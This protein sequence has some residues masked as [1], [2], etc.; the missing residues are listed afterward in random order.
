MQINANGTM[1]AVEEYGPK[2]GL[3]LIL[4]RGLGS[5]LIHWPKNFVQ[6]FADLGYRT[7][8][9]DNRDAGL[10]Q[11][12]PMQDHPSDSASLKQIIADG[13]A[14]PV[15]Y[16]L[17]D[18]VQDCVGLMDEL[19]IN[20]AHLF[21]ISMGGGIAQSF[22]TSFA[23]RLLS[24]TLVMTSARLRS[25]ALLG[26]MLA[27]RRSRSD[28][29]DAMVAEDQVWGSPGYPMTEAEIREQ[30]AQAYDRGYDP[31]AYNRQILGL[32]AAEERVERLQK[33][34]LP[35]FVIHGAEDTLVPPEA[36]RELASLIPGAKLEII[37][38]M[39]HTITPLLAPKLV[40]MVDGFIRGQ[41]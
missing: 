27:K 32:A 5:S 10:S 15:P 41:G 8:I 9:Y 21:A 26:G 39:G 31:D 3:P 6:G 23:D 1:L 36:G 29:I 7:V 17:A 22:A 37:K 16:S 40:A 34:D 38:G 35:C 12:F 18:H 19:G 30:A 11:R 4:V 20:R 24:A 25:A 33:L 28:Y 13:G 14:L 2:D